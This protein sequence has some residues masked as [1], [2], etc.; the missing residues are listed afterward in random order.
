MTDPRIASRFM[1]RESPAGS[2]AV[3]GDAPSTTVVSTMVQTAPL[4]RLGVDAAAAPILVVTALSSSAVSG[5]ASGKG[6]SSERPDRGAPELA[7]QAPR[8]DVQPS[9][10][11]ALH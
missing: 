4:E 8:R 1:R 5:G 11:R 2:T 10:P 7:A 9:T 3:D 6:R